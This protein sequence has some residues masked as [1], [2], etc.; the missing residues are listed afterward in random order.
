METLQEARERVAAA[1]DEGIRCPCC[2]QFA[3]RYRRKLGSG[4]A[5]W[6]IALYLAGAHDAWVHV[7]EAG[8]MMKRGG[9]TVRTGDYAKLRYWGLVTPSPKREDGKSSSGLWRLTERG[10]AFVRGQLEVRR[11]AVV[12]ANELQGFE[13]PLINIRVALGDEFNYDDLMARAAGAGPRY[14]DPTISPKE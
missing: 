12:Y 4:M 2:I 11:C 10:I 1:L 9:S 7:S 8:A 6:L 14:T 13:G 5:R 3:K